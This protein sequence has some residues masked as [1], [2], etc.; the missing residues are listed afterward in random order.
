MPALKAQKIPSPDYDLSY[1]WITGY[2]AFAA[3]VLR[4]KKVPAADLLAPLAGAGLWGTDL[5]SALRRRVPEGVKRFPAFGG[6]FD[7]FWEKL[8]EGPGRLRAVRTA[9][10]LTWR[11]GSAL[12]SERAVVLGWT[13]GAKLEGYIVLLESAREHLRLRQYT[14][15]DLQ[16][17]ND[18][19]EVIL[20]LLAAAREQASR[21]GMHALEWKGWNPAKRKLAAILRPK[22]Y[23]DPVWPAFYKA[24]D[25]DLA[26]VLSQPGAWDFSPL[27]AF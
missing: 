12:R 20:G 22:S 6:E 15:A 16:A 21:A 27:D 4:K 18:V 11:F 2:R 23:R 9:A 5:A 17:L 10:A 1:F 14:I 19:P 7:A 25:P 13:K 24:I 26:P 3:A 8:R